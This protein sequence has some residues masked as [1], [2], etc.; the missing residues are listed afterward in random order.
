[1]KPSEL[2][3]EVQALISHIPNWQTQIRD[4]VA[5]ILSKL[6]DSEELTRS[7]AGLDVTPSELAAIWSIT[8]K[9]PIQV[10]HVREVKRDKRITPSAEWGTGSGRRCLYKVRSV[11]DVK[12]SH[13]KGRPRKSERRNTED[14]A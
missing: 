6:W 4:E 9:T 11:K 8:N 13:E 2:Q 5:T 14:A 7:E 12:V 3:P 10:R 1:M